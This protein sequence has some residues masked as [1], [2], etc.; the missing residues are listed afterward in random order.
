[1][2]AFRLMNSIF[3]SYLAQKSIPNDQRPQSEV[4]CAL[5]DTGTYKDFPTRILGAQAIRPTSANE[6]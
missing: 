4:E 6:T 1:M 3:V 5:T 2:S